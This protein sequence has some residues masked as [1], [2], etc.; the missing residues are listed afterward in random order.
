MTV[1]TKLLEQTP[2]GARYQVL[3][4]LPPRRRPDAEER[5]IPLEFTVT[6]E[7]ALG[8]DNRQPQAKLC[9]RGRVSRALAEEMARTA[10]LQV[11]GALAGRTQKG[12]AR[13]LRLHYRA[14]RLGLMRVHAV[15][16]ELGSPDPD[17][18]DHDNN[19]VLFEHPFRGL[20]QLLRAY[21]RRFRGK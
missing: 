2:Q 12:L 17:A 6:P 15:T 5:R 4:K 8:F 13:E 14:Y 19:A 11:P 7:G 16:A 20:P 10:R 3:V 21:A 1:E 9:A 18:P